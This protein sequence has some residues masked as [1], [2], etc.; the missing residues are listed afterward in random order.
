MIEDASESDED[1]PNNSLLLTETILEEDEDIE[2]EKRSTSSK[3]SP[4]ITPTSPSLPLSDLQKK[5]VVEVIVSSPEEPPK[6]ESPLPTVQIE[7]CEEPRKLSVD[8]R[9]HPNSS[10]FLPPPLLSQSTREAIIP[11]YQEEKQAT[12]EPSISKLA[13]EMLEANYVQEHSK[14]KIANEDV[15]PELL[16]E[17]TPSEKSKASTDLEPQL[18]GNGK[19]DDDEDD[20]RTIGAASAVAV[21]GD[22]EDANM[23]DLVDDI[24]GVSGG[25]LKE[26]FLTLEVDQDDI[27]SRITESSKSSISNLTDNTEELCN[28]NILEIIWSKCS[29]G[30]DYG[31]REIFGVKLRK[32]SGRL[33]QFHS[34][35]LDFENQV[36]VGTQIP[37]PPPADDSVS[38]PPQSS[39][40][41]LQSKFVPSWPF[42]PKSLAVSTELDELDK[43]AIKA[44]LIAQQELEQDLNKLTS[45][46]IAEDRITTSAAKS[47]SLVTELK[48]PDL[49]VVSSED[50]KTPKRDSIPGIPY[51][52]RSVLKSSESSRQSSRRSSHKSTDISNNNLESLVYPPDIQTYQTTFRHAPGL[53]KYSP[54]NQTSQVK[55]ESKLT[56]RAN[57]TSNETHTSSKTSIS[58][59]TNGKLETNKVEDYSS[60][61]HWKPLLA[62]ESADSGRS[63]PSS[64][65]SFPQFVHSVYPLRKMSTNWGSE[66]TVSQQDV[67]SEKIEGSVLTEESSESSTTISNCSIKSVRG[68][69]EESIEEQEEQLEEMFTESEALLRSSSKEISVIEFINETTSANVQKSSIAT[70]EE[71]K[72][73]QETTPITAG[74]SSF[75]ED[76][77]EEAIQNAK[78][79]SSGTSTFEDGFA[80]DLI[81]LNSKDSFSSVPYQNLDGS[82]SDSSTESSGSNQSEV[83]NW[84]D[85]SIDLSEILPNGEM[86][87]MHKNTANDTSMAEIQVQVC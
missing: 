23:K 18:N 56:F 73:H 33:R 3:K 51:F 77:A 30:K 68:S 14:G 38:S 48:Q 10:E 28:P 1:R 5:S 81:R 41:S 78:E 20:R 66:S 26:Q 39:K 76:C 29:T 84:A 25:F 67:A 75:V 70:E 4:L 60:T 86:R 54:E 43:E 7:V 74:Q 82:S 37:T 45:D 17:K 21:L 49:N 50:S 53:W 40:F 19:T 71:Q 57:P 58:F 36:S 87:S 34:T 46:P 80:S 8:L 62:S 22:D 2:S 83:N 15:T 47:K 31:Y 32:I 79:S 64:V 35:M 61:D 16:E 65:S 24:M 72:L 6:K 13:K 52:C 42:D 9:K 11:Y 27:E 59:A 44:A 69:S 12:D 55:V 63:T 85:L